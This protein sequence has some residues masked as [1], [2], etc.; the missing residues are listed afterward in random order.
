MTKTTKIV[1][2]ITIIIALFLGAFICILN[3]LYPQK[4]N[5]LISTYST[6]YELN[7]VLVASII[8][9]ESGYNP[10]AISNAGAV[11]LMQ[12]K[13][14]TASWIMD[15]TITEEQLTEPELNIQIGCLYLSMMLA[16]FENLECALAGYNAGPNNVES[17]LTMEEYST[18]GVTLNTIPFEE[19]QL[20]I[21]KIKNNMKIYSFLMS[22]K[23]SLKI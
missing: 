6:E 13:P 16:Q 11:G 20:Y 23:T 19:T 17:W 14:S 2:Y 1:F 5:D 10:T 22:T 12:V 15:T 21:E 3:Y 7:P 4:Y 8:N 18:D 9:V